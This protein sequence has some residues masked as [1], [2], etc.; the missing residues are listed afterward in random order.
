LPS[1][2]ITLKQNVRDILNEYSQNSKGKFK[3]EYI[4]PGNDEK[5]ARELQ[6]LGI[7]QLQFEVS[8]KDKLQLVNG[9]LGIAIS[10]GGNTEAIPVVEQDATNLEYQIT[11]SIKKVVK[12]EIDSIGYLTSNGTAG[13]DGDL[14]SGKKKLEELYNIQRVDL[15]GK[16]PEI[17]AAIKT[18]LVVGP[19]SKFSNEELKAINMFV[20]NGG[21]LVILADG[22]TLKEGLAAEPNELGLDPL[23]GA[24]GIKLNKDLA[25]D[26]RKNY[27]SFTQGFMRF[28]LPYPFWPKVEKPDFDPKNS[29]VSGL[30]SVTFPW[31]ST[32]SIDESKIGSDAKVS[33]LARTSS[34]GWRVTSDFDLNPQ[35]NFT[36][37][38]QEQLNLAVSVEGKLKSAYPG[39]KEPG[40][41]ANGK[42]VVVGDSDFAK[43]NLNQ[44]S[45][46]NLTFFQNIVDSVT[47]DPDLIAI[48]SK[49]V[50]SRPIKEQSDSSR[51][52]IRYFNVFGVTAL[53]LMFG[54]T[55][56][57]LRRRKRY[58][59]EM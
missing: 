3:V 56:Y 9:Y 29:S 49:G 30:E 47:I 52:F 38:K 28:S 55:R 2:F 58:L 5:I 45:R 13:L 54:M 31:V 23:L 4:D 37:G 32:I 19:T 50:S 46:D 22:V 53:A 35:Q 34:K 16:N 15:S 8:E 17:P 36:P 11:T 25:L 20:M 48:R 21:G 43:E 26:E 14:A 42:I 57:Y 51:A 33:Y 39:G 18:L 24:Y 6:M 12:K 44:L 27:A 7:P 10:Y 40:E 59:E 41:T 1:Q